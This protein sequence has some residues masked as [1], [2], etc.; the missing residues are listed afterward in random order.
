MCT[1]AVLLTFHFTQTLNFVVVFTEL[2]KAE[3]AGKTHWFKSN[4]FRY[5]NSTAQSNIMMG[6]KG[7]RYSKTWTY[8]LVKYI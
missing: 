2:R 7:K 8:K 5:H 6:I 1:F 4:S 3:D